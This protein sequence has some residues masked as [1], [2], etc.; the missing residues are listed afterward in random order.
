MSNPWALS[1]TFFPSNGSCRPFIA[2][3]SAHVYEIVECGLDTGEYVCTRESWHDIATPL[4]PVALCAAL[5]QH[6][7]SQPV[8][9]VPPAPGLDG[10]SVC[11]SL[12]V[13]HSTTHSSHGAMYRWIP[14]CSP[15]KGLRIL[16]SL[17]CLLSLL[18]LETF[19]PQEYHGPSFTRLEDQRHRLSTIQ[20]SDRSVAFTVY[21]SGRNTSRKF[22]TSAAPREW[23]ARPPPARN[24]QRYTHTTLLSVRSAAAAVPSWIRND[25]TP[26]QVS[27]GSAMSI[28]HG[29]RSPEH[30]RD[31]V[32]QRAGSA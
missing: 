18:R 31:P 22:T 5:V 2:R 30:A 14:T 7:L 8:G 3:V 13:R 29:R 16:P 17:L 32:A 23:S 10:R 21:A 11:L 25:D 20:R 26:L 6:C 28:D 9:S 12:R 24:A 19:S 4:S 15:H 1:P 27:G